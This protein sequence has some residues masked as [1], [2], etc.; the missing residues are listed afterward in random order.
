MPN[1][2]YRIPA[3]PIEI[4]TWITEMCIIAPKVMRR[5]TT[6]E[7]GDLGNW[8][9]TE[10][11]KNLVTSYPG[12]KP[13]RGCLVGSAALAFNELMSCAVTPNW[14]DD[15]SYYIMAEFL[16]KCIPELGIDFEHF[17][18]SQDDCSTELTPEEE[19]LLDFC[20]LTQAAGGEAGSYA[21]RIEDA[22]LYMDPSEAQ[23]LAVKE[24]KKFIRKALT[25]Q[26]KR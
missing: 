25:A 1:K 20:S 23:E 13:I 26:A 22:N 16:S 11:G 8:L 17:K 10:D 19:G 4:C 6:M 7:F 3:L 12:A 21:F 15:T 2:K 24:F 14:N 5:V 18:L 9:E